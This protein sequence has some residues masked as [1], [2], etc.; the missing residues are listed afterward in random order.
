MTED[1]GK[2][3]L[4]LFAGFISILWS[5]AREERNIIVFILI[6]KIWSEF[7][8]DCNGMSIKTVTELILIVFNTFPIKGL[9]VLKR[10]FFKN[11]DPNE[12]TVE[13]LLPN[14]RKIIFV[15]KQL[16][17]AESFT[18]PWQQ[19]VYVN[20]NWFLFKS[21]SNVTPTSPVDAP[22][23]EHTWS[24]FYQTPILT[25]SRSNEQHLH[26][27]AKICF[28]NAFKMFKNLFLNR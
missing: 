22:L 4:F 2:L 24:K 10:D 8:C 15:G 23:L 11:V 12:V 13:L 1:I 16:E 21:S 25:H 9:T 7:R 20:N 28:G 18:F 3:L 19:H 6:R 17:T 26:K 27:L 14:K 5:H